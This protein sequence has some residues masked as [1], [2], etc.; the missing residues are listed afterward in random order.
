MKSS[1]RK[2]LKISA[3]SSAALA[4]VPTLSTNLD[5]QEK[6]SDKKGLKVAGYD[7][8][9]VKG[10]MTGRISIGKWS[11]SFEPRGINTLNSSMFDGDQMYDVSE[12]GMV[13]YIVAYVNEGFRD[14]ELLPIFPLRVF[15]HKS[16]FIR[17]DGEVK[18]PQDLKG[19]KICTPGY[20]STSLTW[21]RGMLKDEYG[22]KPEDVTWVIAEQASNA[23]LTGNTSKQEHF[24]PEGINVEKGPEGMDESD[25]LVSGIV[26]AV[27]HAVE[28]VAFMK[29]D[30][31]VIRLFEDSREVE[32]KYFKKTKVFPIMHGVAVR[33]SLVKKHREL[34][35]QVFE[36]YSNSKTMLYG[37]MR[38]LGWA[39]DSLPW[40]AQEFEATKELMG[41][42]Y[43]SYGFEE[44]KKTLDKLV[45]YCF[46]QGLI[47]EKIKAE[48]L[49]HKPSL[50][51]N[52]S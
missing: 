37:F 51:F 13:P 19:K 3:L 39:Y 46:D 4:S 35:E 25:L 30:P 44:N 17:K 18:K 43:Y 5:S 14:Y 38:K 27:F 12:I 42:N 34:P 15:R 21:I 52:E 9:R 50:D 36:A 10:L 26:D 22:V 20:S 49:F 8:P 31:N 32:Q 2:F 41:D 7:Y 23:K 11:H 47:K 16:I 28:P 40:Y 6:A 24:I 33:K 29:G 45:K 48:D 1:R